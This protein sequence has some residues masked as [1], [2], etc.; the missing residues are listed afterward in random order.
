MTPQQKKIVNQR[1]SA[2]YRTVTALRYRV[3]H[4]AAITCSGSGQTIDMSAGGIAIEI[5]RVLE[6]GTELELSLDWTGL[7]HGKRRMRLF[8]WGEVVRSDEQSTAMRIL[9]HEFREVA[10]RAVA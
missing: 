2:R 1:A 5:G 6:P 8:L 9:T 10:A 7:Y 4:Q 3:F